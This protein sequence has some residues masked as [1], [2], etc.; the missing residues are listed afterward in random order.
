MEGAEISLK[1][2]KYVRLTISLN[3]L[4]FLASLLNLKLNLLQ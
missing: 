4:M 2:V 1:Q 3:F